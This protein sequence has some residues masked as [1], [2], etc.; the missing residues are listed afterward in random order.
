MHFVV[1]W[2]IQAEGEAWKAANAA[3]KE[4]LSGYS[5]VKPL[6]T[7]YIVRIRNEEAYESIKESIKEVARTSTVTVHFLV[8]P[9]MHGGRYD[10]WLP[11]SMWPMIRERAR[12]NE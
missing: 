11:K 2:D 12:D 6:T 4:C 8:T 10:G 9:V 5:W 1:S 7:L 3:L